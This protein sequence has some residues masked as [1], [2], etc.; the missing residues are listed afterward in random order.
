MKQLHIEKPCSESWDSMTPT[1]KGAFCQ[2]CAK[3]V[4]DFTSKTHEEIRATFM[5]MSGKEICGN[6]M[7]EQMDSFNTEAKLWQ[8]NSSRAFQSRMVFSLVVVFGLS[9]FSCTT[10]KEKKTILKMQETIA[11]TLAQRE[12]DPITRQ[13][14]SVLPA[15]KPVVEQAPEMIEEIVSGKDS[16]MGE[17][18]EVQVPYTLTRGAIRGAMELRTIVRSTP[19]LV[20]VEYD[21]NGIAIPTELQSKAFPNPAT[22]STTLEIGLPQND[23]MEISLYDLNGQFIRTVFSGDLKRGTRIFPVDLMDVPVGMYLFVIHSKNYSGTT[24]IIKV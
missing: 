10:E 23:F 24:R 17:L 1:E 14:L 6:I 11:Q 5:E 3:E 21:E 9:L 19:E 8:L 15:R 13:T 4:I 18:E 12:E 2:K 20:V 16:I 7:P 22:T